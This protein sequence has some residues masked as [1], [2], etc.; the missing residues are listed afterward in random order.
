M[1]TLLLASD[2]FKGT[3][4]SQRI[5]SL[6][7][8]MIDKEFSSSWSLDP[9]PLADG[10]EGTLEAV[11][12]SLG[13]EFRYVPVVDA[14]G[15][16]IHAPILFLSES[17]AAIEVSSVL[18]LP[19]VEGKVPPLER[20]SRGL[21]M[22]I[23]EA[24]RMGA[25][26]II[27][28]LGGSCTNDMGIGTLQEM[29]LD[30]GT[31]ES[32]TMANCPQV[33][34]LSWGSFLEAI[35]GVSFSCLCDVD[36]P[37]LGKEGATFVYGPQKGYG[38]SLDYLE[39][40]MGRL[41]SLAFSLTGVDVSREEKLG[42]AGGLGACFRAVFGARMLSGISYL[43]ELS[44]F[45]ERAEKA[46]LII[47]GE[48]RFDS[49]SLKGKVFSGVYSSCDPKKLVVLCGKS[50]VEN[51]PLPVYQTSRPGERFEEAKRKAEQEYQS[52]LREILLSRA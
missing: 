9:C 1:K 42:A 43:L 35:R 31:K 52:A 46:D 48:G 26:D 23:K 10:G 36:S 50:E 15:K 21:G 33:Q 39:K 44:H 45:K 34:S 28:G 20:S 2:S 14:E 27:V 4:S 38:D 24:I 12:Q 47:T 16:P 30:F 41:S 19:S 8:E 5:I 25:N 18:G 40:E 49:Q 3:L 22:L 17:R 6:A 51:P 11:H 29:G 13:G 37:L 32:V 7:H